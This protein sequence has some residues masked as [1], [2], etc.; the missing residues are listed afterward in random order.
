LLRRIPGRIAGRTAGKHGNTGH[1]L[2][3]QT[4]DQHIRRDRA[5]SNICTSH[6]LSALTAAA[7]LTL[8]GTQGVQDVAYPSLQQ[9]P[10]AQRALP[11]LPGFSAAWERPFFHEFVVR[12]SADPEE[13]VQRLLDY[14]IIGGLPL[15]RFYPELSDAI[16]FCVTEARTK[17]EI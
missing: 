2:T 13:L 14:Q 17:E 10:Y 12:T 8:L 11:A 3:L 16:L 1:V 9:A 4:R 7:S 6:R 5:T 15:G